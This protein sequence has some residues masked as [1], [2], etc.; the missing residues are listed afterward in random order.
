MKAVALLV[1][2]S[3]LMAAQQAAQEPP[4]FPALPDDTVVAV[5]DDGTK[6]TMGE[7][8]AFY[9]VLPQNSQLGMLHDRKSFLEQWALLRKLAAVSEEKKLNE[10]SPSKE[11]LEYNRLLVLSQAAINDELLTSSP[12]PADIEKY[13]EANKDRYKLVKVKAIYITFSKEPASKLGPNGKPLLT[14]ELAREKAQKLLAEIRGGADFVKLVKENSEDAAS[15]EKDGDFATLRPADNIPDAIK[16]AVFALKQGEVSEPVE[17]PNGFYLLRADEISYRPLAEVRGDILET[18]KQ[19][20][21]RQWMQK[22][23]DSVKVQFPNQQF[24]SNVQG[25]PGK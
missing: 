8:K 1:F 20:H 2:L 25:T 3:G 24:L 19:D 10:T 4:N 17:Q 6:M 5:F 12:E 7:F 14:E 16:N 21:F 9:N 15:K 23:H 18:F 13:Y 22:M 11:A